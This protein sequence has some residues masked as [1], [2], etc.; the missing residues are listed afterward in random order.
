MAEKKPVRDLSNPE[1]SHQDESRVI[2]PQRLSEE[3]RKILEDA[4]WKPGDPVPE[5]LS[6]LL[7]STS[8]ELPEDHPLREVLADGSGDLAEALEEAK[9]QAKE[10][11]TDAQFQGSDSVKDALKFARDQEEQWQKEPEVVITDDDEPEDKT[12]PDK[13]KRCPRCGFDTSQTDH[14]VVEEEDKTNY[15]QCVLGGKH[16]KKEYDLLGGQ[17]QVV[18]RTLSPEESDACYRQTYL[19]HKGSL[20]GESPV[21]IEMLLRYCM[22]LQLHRAKMGRDVHLFPETLEG[23]KEQLKCDD[24]VLPHIKKHVSSVCIRSDTMQRVLAACLRDFNL[25]VMKLEANARNSDFWLPA[26]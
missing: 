24:P 1:E 11:A 8:A 4:G 21:Y 3:E 20:S 13:D 12:T 18:F 9:K 15:L 6:E 2:Y 25:L 14:I 26:R 17:L 7:G 10:A 23:W 16:F 22:T 19:D 5:N